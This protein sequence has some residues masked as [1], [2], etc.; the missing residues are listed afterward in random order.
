MAREPGGQAREGGA[1]APRDRSWDGY[2][3][4]DERPPLGTYAVLSS[5]FVAAIGAFLVAG[6]RLTC[7][8]CIGMWI[9]GALTTGIVVAPRETR[10]VASLLS[11]LGLADFLQVGY[12]SAV[13]RREP[14]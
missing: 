13:A 9:V 2:A 8:Y 3:P 5:G 6:R 4:A 7:P 12:R 10:F 11:A 1:P 14:S